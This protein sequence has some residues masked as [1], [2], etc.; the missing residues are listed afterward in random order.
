MPDGS[1]GDGGASSGD[2]GVSAGGAGAAGAAV[3]AE[4]PPPLLDVID[5]SFAFTSATPSPAA[6]MF[7]HA[8]TQ[9]TIARA[10]PIHAQMRSVDERVGEA[11]A[12]LGDEPD[13]REDQEQDRESRRDHRVA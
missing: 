6:L 7:I 4:E 8:P 13:E 5:D 12:R 2:A 9:T 3:D 10:S 11:A 1:L